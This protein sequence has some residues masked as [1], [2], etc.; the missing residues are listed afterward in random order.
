MFVRVQRAWLLPMVFLA[1]CGGAQKPPPEDTVEEAARLIP[2]TL[3]WATAYCGQSDVTLRDLDVA[4]DG[5]IGLVGDLIGGLRDGSAEEEP[6]YAPLASPD[7]DVETFFFATLTADGAHEA[8][9]VPSRHKKAAMASSVRSVG[10]GEWVVGGYF[11]DSLRLNADSPRP[12]LTHVR[13]EDVFMLVFNDEARPLGHIVAGGR[14]DERVD[15]MVVNAEGE[16]YL[17]GSYVQSVRFHRRARLGSRKDHNLFLAK[18]GDDGQVA[19]VKHLL[20]SKRPLT[21]LRMLVASDGDLL[22]AGT[23]EESLTYGERRSARTWTSRGQ[24]DVFLARWDAIGELRWLEQGGSEGDDQLSSLSVDE[25]DQISLVA[26]ANRAIATTQ[27]DAPESGL[28]RSGGQFI[29][30][31][32][33]AE[34]GSL[35]QVR[36]LASGSAKILHASATSLED[37]GT[38]IVGAF[39]GELAMRGSEHGPIASAGGS[40]FI[41]RLYPDDRLAQ[42]EATEGGGAVAS[43]VRSHPEGGVIVGGTFQGRTTLSLGAPGERTLSCD[44]RAGVF[45]AHYKQ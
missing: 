26:R 6:R 27:Q 13:G 41:A 5:R 31:H 20:S 28:V 30:A 39:E 34:D 40:A 7:A 42:V 17:V 8:I 12:E 9:F 33:A 10:D 3:L 24:R 25:D 21:D 22:L 36:R 44:G 18:L 37:G 19:W 23:F 2:Q 35:H 4:N 45:V 14:G 29:V 1:A 32:Y 16:I 11:S 15:A 38:S 43:Q